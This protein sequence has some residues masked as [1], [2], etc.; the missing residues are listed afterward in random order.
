LAKKQNKIACIILAAGLSKRFGGMKQLAILSPGSEPLVQ[1]A[2]DV[3]N[4]SS[5]DY[6]ILVLGHSSSQIAAKIYLGR[7][8]LVLN[9][10]YHDGLSTSVKCGLSNVPSDADAAIFMVADQPFL[11]SDILDML[12][13]KYRQKRKKV[14]AL[15]PSFKK[16]PR[17]PVLLDRSM[18]K[19]VSLLQGDIGAREIVRRHIDTVEFLEIDDQDV[20]LDVDTK[21]SLEEA[22]KKQKG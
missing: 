4:A 18:F 13:A 12:A 14:I 17:N 19:E 9:K 20:F 8:N 11:T 1:M 2:I 15:T 10:D 22:M 16:E 3:A 5:C 7:A 21:T 6:V